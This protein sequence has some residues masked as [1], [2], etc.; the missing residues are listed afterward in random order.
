[1]STTTTRI[2]YGDG[3]IRYV[4]RTIDTRCWLDVA[5][6]FPNDAEGTRRLIRREFCFQHDQSLCI[7][8]VLTRTSTGLSFDT[9]IFLEGQTT[10]YQWHHSN[11]SA[12]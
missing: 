10:P 9:V 6:Q 8:Y 4:P 11:L 2:L 3:V 1:M 12:A 7:E 5:K